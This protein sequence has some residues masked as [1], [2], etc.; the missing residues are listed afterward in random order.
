[1]ADL[2]QERGTSRK[3]DYNRSVEGTEKLKSVD[4]YLGTKESLQQFKQL[5]I[6]KYRE[7]GICHIQPPRTR[8]VRVLYMTY[9]P[10]FEVFN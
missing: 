8:S 7:G 1:M 4:I 9:I 6:V 3:I 5:V 2:Q 10:T